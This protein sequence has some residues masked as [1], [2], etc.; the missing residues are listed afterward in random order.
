MREIARLRSAR[1]PARSARAARKLAPPKVE[2]DAALYKKRA[3]QT[4]LGQRWRELADPRAAAAR[5]R[6]RVRAGDLGHRHDACAAEKRDGV[7]LEWQQSAADALV[8]LV[9]AGAASS[10]TACSAAARR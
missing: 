2:D 4:E 9:T 3:L 6:P 1:R 8:S 5:A 10:A 7:V